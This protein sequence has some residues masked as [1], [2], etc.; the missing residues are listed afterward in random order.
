MAVSAESMSTNRPS[1]VRLIF[2]YDGDDVRLVFQQRVDVA[3]TDFTVAQA[4]PPGHYV[5]VRTSE[6]R[7]LTRVPVLGAFSPSVEVFGEPGTPITRVEVERSAGSFT[8]VVPASEVATCV[9]LL[10]VEPASS[11]AGEPA[12]TLG[13][14]QHTTELL[15]AEL[16]AERDDHDDL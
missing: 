2:E 1:A 14:G 6:G 11:V 9:S 12:P 7:S 8:V 5:E 16:N 3:V 15:N 4:S 10:R 13:S